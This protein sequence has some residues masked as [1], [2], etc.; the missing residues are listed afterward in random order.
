MIFNSWRII[1]KQVLKLD[2]FLFLSLK[3]SQYLNGI[4]GTIFKWAKE[5]REQGQ[6]ATCDSRVLLGMD[7]P[8]ISIWNFNI[9]NRIVHIWILVK[10]YKFY[11]ENSKIWIYDDNKC[12]KFTHAKRFEMLVRSS[13]WNLNYKIIINSIWPKQRGISNFP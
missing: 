12:L 13:L 5:S 3:I 7:N 11:V 2:S 4:I 9:F 1:I 8:I 6:R 10:A